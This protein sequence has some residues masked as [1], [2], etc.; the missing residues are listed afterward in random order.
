MDTNRKTN[1]VRIRDISFGQFLDHCRKPNAPFFTYIYFP[2]TFPLSYIFFRLHFSANLISILGIYMSIIGG[3][4][5]LMGHL[6]W[7]IVVILLSYILDFCDGNVARMRYGHLGYSRAPQKLGLM[8]E[9]LYANVSYAFFFV[10]IGWYLFIETEQVVILFLSVGAYLSKIIS[11]YTIMHVCLL[12][13]KDG[14]EQTVQ[15]ILKDG[16]PNRIKYFITNIFDNARCYFI[17]SVAVI[18]FFPG[19]FS[20]FFSAYCVAIIVINLTK[21]HLTLIRKAP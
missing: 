16:N 7:G 2:I 4:V 14:T 10:P 5:I 12:N 11:R 3:A 13:R 9:N 8:L 17:S 20:L 21:L 18:L 15:G 6:L 19:L 1:T